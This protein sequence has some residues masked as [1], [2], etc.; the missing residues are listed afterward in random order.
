[1]ANVQPIGNSAGSDG[2]VCYTYASYWA[3]QVLTWWDPWSPC[4]RCAHTGMNL[5]GADLSWS[6]NVSVSENAGLDWS[7]INDMLGASAGVSLTTT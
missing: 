6:F 3:E 4:S 2:D 1:M 7:R 5:G